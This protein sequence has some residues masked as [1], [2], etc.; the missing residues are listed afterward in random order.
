MTA[1]TQDRGPETPAVRPGEGGYSIPARRRRRRVRSARS[2]ERRQRDP[3]DRARADAESATAHARTAAD[4]AAASARSGTDELKRRA[5]GV[6]DDAKERA[7]AVAG[8][9]K[10]L[11][12]ERLTGFA[13]ALRHASSDLDEQGQSVVSGFVRQA[14]DGLEHFSGAMRRNDVDD[15][16]G[17][18]EDFARRQPAVFIGSAVLAG[19]GIARFMKSSSERRRERG[20]ACPSAPATSAGAAGTARGPGTPYEGGV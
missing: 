5:Q 17:S 12:A 10:N 2:L 9:Q 15:L 20:A 6:V 7:Q 16:V 1:S 19:F 3:A 4:E 18:I 13:D 11:A 14:A 8:E